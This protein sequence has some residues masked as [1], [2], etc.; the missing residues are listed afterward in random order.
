METLYNYQN[1]LIASTEFLFCRPLMEEVAWNERLIGILGPRGAGKT[2]L[3]LQQLMEPPYPD[4]TRLYLSLDNLANPYPTLISLAETFH[5]QGGKQLIIDEIHK[6]PGWAG[7][8]KTIYDLFPGLNVV[9]S[10]SS[11]L[12]LMY[13]GVDLSRRAVIYY[14]NGLSFREF[15]QI[16]TGK[17]LPRF[18]LKEILDDH[19]SIS[20]SIVKKIRPLQFFSDYLQHGYFPFFLQGTSTYF[21]KLQGIINYILETEIPAISNLDVRNIRKIKRAL[22]I[23]AA[24]VP[25]QPNITKLAAALE[26]NRNTLLQYLVFLEQTGII[27]SLYHEGSLYGRLTK[28]GKILLSHPNHSFTLSAGEVNIESIREGFFVNQVRNGNTVELA[29]KGDFLVNG[30]YTFEI[31]GKSK[32]RKQIIGAASGYIAIDDAELGYENKIPL[33]LFG[34]LY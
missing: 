3:L 28:P 12:R 2:T 20:L 17:P 18:K 10:G 23:I 14:L 16:R 26:L 7:E 34:F 19:E 6:Y 5:R 29:T 30:K 24:H 11:I 9:F 21:L 4:K 22:Q 27:V 31:G 33:W 25:Y 13:E 1:Q 15:I 32:N 8:I